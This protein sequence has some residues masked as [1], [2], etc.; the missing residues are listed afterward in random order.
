MN[1]TIQAFGLL[2][3][4]SLVIA[5]CK[6]DP[7]PE[8]SAV[9]AS[10]QYEVSETNWAEV[11]FTNY[12]ANATSS[13]WDFGDGNTSTETSPTHVYDAGGVY[14]VTLTATGLDGS[15]SDSLHL[16]TARML[17]PMVAQP[18]QLNVGN[19]LPRKTSTSIVFPSCLHGRLKLRDHRMRESM[20]LVG[21]VN[22]N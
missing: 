4:A 21:L 20:K 6:P 22:W 5:S 10:F 3:I 7:V 14:E 1:K 2:I 11:T 9:I 15:A 18:S 16:E 19:F 17:C 13:I 12:S 8:P